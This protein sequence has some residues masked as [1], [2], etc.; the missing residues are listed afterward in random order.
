MDLQTRSTDTLLVIILILGL[1]S[2]LY[3]VEAKDEPYPLILFPGGGEIIKDED[4]ISY[5]NYQFIAHSFDG[6]EEK[7][8]QFDLFDTV[9]ADYS[10]H[11]TRNIMNLSRQDIFDPKDKIKGKDWLREKLKEITSISKV[12][13]LEIKNV[14]YNIYLSDNSI[15]SI[16]TKRI[17]TIAN[18]DLTVNE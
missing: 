9:P 2:Q 3:F 12:R 17:L 1:F 18:L 10:F 7:V 5:S 16:R 4:R 8:K 15:D 11:I 14:S 13:K 6:R